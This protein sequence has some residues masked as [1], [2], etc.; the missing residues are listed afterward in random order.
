MHVD[1]LKAGGIKNFTVGNA[2]ESHP[3][4]EEDGL[5][6]WGVGEF[7]QHPEINFFEA[8]LQRGG[9]ITVT[10]F[11][12]LIGTAHGSEVASQFGREQFAESGGFGGFRPAHF[13]AGAMVDE[14][15]EAET[16]TV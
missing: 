10:L 8:G 4:S 7:A 15:V 6:A 11:K 2:I 9:E 13:G 16:E 5:H 12:R 1:L 3:T 14:V